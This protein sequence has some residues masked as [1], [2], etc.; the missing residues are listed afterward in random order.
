MRSSTDT[1]ARSLERKR[2]GRSAHIRQTVFLL[3][4]LLAGLVISFV[5]VRYLD[6]PKIGAIA[7]PERLISMPVGAMPA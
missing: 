6:P 5:V 1:D 2:A 3:A 7:A 4:L